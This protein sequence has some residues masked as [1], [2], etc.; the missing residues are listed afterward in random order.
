[1]S[2]QPSTIHQ[3]IGT[4]GKPYPA[5][6]CFNPWI[7]SG[8]DV[9]A[10]PRDGNTV[11]PLFSGKDYFADLVASVDGA[12]EEV[13]ILGWQVN[14][15]AMLAPG[16]R[17]YDLIYRNA[18]RG[19]RFYVMPWDDTNPVQTYDDQTRIVL[20]NI[21]RR[22]GQ[23][24]KNARVHVLLS[25]A[26]PDINAS[27][28]SHHQKCVV[29]DRQIGYMGGID[30]AYGRYD[31]AT[32]T[33][34]PDADGRSVL[35]RYNPGIPGMKA[36]KQSEVVDP[37]LLSGLVDNT[38][39]STWA[40]LATGMTGTVVPM[41]VGGDNKSPAEIVAD[42]IHAGGRQ[43]PYEPNWA[44]ANHARTDSNT[45]DLTTLDENTQ[46]RMPWQ[47]VHCRIEGP[48]V[49]D[50]ARNFVVRWNAGSSTK[51]PLPDAPETYPKPGKAKVQFL[52]SAPASMRQREYKAAKDAF[53]SPPQGVDNGIHQAMLRL[54]HNAA[55]FIYIES[56]FFVSDFGQV[57]GPQSLSPAGEFI[58]DGPKRISDLKL[59]LLRRW[60]DTEGPTL[61]GL[62]RNRVCQALIERIRQAIMD[63]KKPDFHVY[64]TLPV[65][66]E[67]AL[68]DPTVAVQVYWT[69]Q[70]LANG[71]HSLL[72]GIRRAL[73]ARELRD[74]KKPYDR[75]I[76]DPN[77]REYEDIPVEACD[78]YVTLL[79]LRNWA[80]FGDRYV[81]EQIY[82]HSKMMVVDDRFALL[83]S[84]NIN[85]RSLLGMRDSEIAV[86]VIDAET[87]LCDIGTGAKKP[88]RTFARELRTGVW[89][90][91]FGITGN[92][93]PA[94]HL[95]GAIDKPANPGSWQAIQAQARSNTVALEESFSF[96]PRNWNG[97]DT[98]NNPLPA[99]IL[100]TWRSKKLT[101]P[102][103]WQNIFWMSQTHNASG[104][105][106]LASI[107]GFI[108]TLPIHWTETE[109]NNFKFPTS[110]VADNDK[111]K[112]PTKENAMA[113]NQ[114]LDVNMSNV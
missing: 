29:V 66:P 76:T 71:S 55:H 69:M 102:L 79:N 82:V 78:Q 52:R 12:K 90:K 63:A 87:S 26:L 40:A 59:S 32:Y 33:L 35:N 74:K 1:M 64:I 6:G 7:G 17:L 34:K 20:D 43:A 27:Y 3:I 49:S 107:R 70:T 51:L 81:T 19:I 72:N 67:G 18:K 13:L 100:P 91:L 5:T 101:S 104:S 31:D 68:I 60:D 56:Q 38:R 30:L 103:P 92:V 106:A 61:D 11:K 88:V 86:L 109:N 47:D 28:F 22:L 45:L 16:L 41:P 85:D 96:I 24:G 65:H 14:W 62:P 93:R 110:L 84:A 54:I 108:S 15:D 113:S 21:N 98:D 9:F 44:V 80:K 53:T 99:S 4:D 89:K 39:P 95:Q 75:V 111:S 77:N 105:S 37:D 2:R 46:P 8:S 48:V 97:I 112:N 114:A 10:M 83:G 25:A 36:L 50:L 42:K 23:T 58:K 94:S 73:K 57:Q